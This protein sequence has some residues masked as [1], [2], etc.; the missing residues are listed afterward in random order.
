LGGSSIGSGSISLANAS[1]YGEVSNDRA[2]FSVSSAGDVNG[3]GFDDVLI[4][5]D[6]NDEGG[7]NSG[8]A[9]IIYGGEGISSGNV[10]LA[11]V[12]FYG[13]PGSSSGYAVSSAGDVNGD[14]F[15]DIM[16]GA[17]GWNLG[18]YRGKT[19]IIYGGENI[20]SGNISLANASFYGENDGEWNGKSISGAGDVNGDG[21]DDMI[22][23][24]SALGSNTGKTYIIYGGENI[25]SGNISLANVSFLGENA[26]D[27][28]GL[29]VSG[30]GDVNGDV[31]IS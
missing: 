1:F 31:K 23:G 25:S 21:F 6:D 17:L 10:S 28:S 12:S 27:L 4:G 26:G 11:N 15:D 8:K 29:S 16:I 19:Y 7:E 20:S 22:M 5:A 30:A 14:G 13:E 24:V 18:S 3:D 9:Y 2:G